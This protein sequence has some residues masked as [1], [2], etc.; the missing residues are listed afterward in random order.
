MKSQSDSTWYATLCGAA[1][2]RSPSYEPDPPAQ[3][4]RRGY[5][6]HRD[7]LQEEPF[8]GSN[9][10]RIARLAW[11]RTYMPPAA[12]FQAQF[13]GFQLRACIP[14]VYHNEHAACGLSSPHKSAG[15]GRS[16]LASRVSVWTRGYRPNAQVLM[17]IFA[18]TA[19]SYQYASCA[20]VKLQGRVSFAS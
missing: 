12:A 16:A 4:I 5:S 15:R 8:L 6:E 20:S 10:D 14:C 1:L 13:C 9:R 17:D 19:G 2:P 11:Y 3:H 7:E 18:R